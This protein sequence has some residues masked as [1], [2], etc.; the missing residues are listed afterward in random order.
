MEREAALPEAFLA[1]SS[2]LPLPRPPVVRVPSPPPNMLLRTPCILGM[3]VGTPADLVT[4]AIAFLPDSRTE[5]RI[6]T[7]GALGGGAGGWD[8]GAPM[9]KDAGSLELNGVI[10]SPEPSGEPWLKESMP[11]S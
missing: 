4:A 3:T 2:I 5:S 6:S 11:G 7:G 9:I 1:L 10:T 8:D